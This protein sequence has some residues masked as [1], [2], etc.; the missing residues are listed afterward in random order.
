MGLNQVN[1]FEKFI[2]EYVQ[3]SVDHTLPATGDQDVKYVLQLQMNRL[4]NKG[5]SIQYE[6]EPRGHFGEGG[7]LYI[8]WND[9]IYDNFQQ[10]RT[11]RLTRT[12]YRNGKVLQEKKQDTIFYQIIT[13]SMEPQ[14]PEDELYVCPSCGNVVRIKE[15]VEGCSYCG[16]QFQASEL[17][18]KVSSFFHIRDHGKTDKEIKSGMKRTILPC[19]AIA[20]M[21]SFLYGLSQYESP[22]RLIFMTIIP[23]IIYGGLGGYL[24]YGGKLLG[25]LLFDAG[26]ALQPVMN[27]AG[28]KK[29]FTEFMK[30]FTPDFSYDYFNSKVCSMLKTILFSETENQV[31]F[32]QGRPLDSSFKDILE[33]NLS[34]NA[35]VRNFHVKG[36]YVSLTVEMYMDNI[37]ATGNGVKS[38]RDIFSMKMCRN[39]S[40]PLNYNFSIHKISCK[41]CGGSFDAG[42]HR[43]CPYCDTPYPIQDEDWLITEIR[44]F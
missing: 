16:T 17:F 3:Y 28:S 43:N 25:R 42:K 20:T 1:I 5:Y 11:C 7:G 30:Q 13:S 38:K 26:K 29:K 23:G 9:D 8:H 40:R 4:K 10:Y 33:S 44:K 31:P 6:Y 27:S 36:N 15:L 2:E 37:Y 32:Y 35:A 12:I 34:S 19:I 41:S 22:I 21:G 39:I 24:I 14:P 18:P